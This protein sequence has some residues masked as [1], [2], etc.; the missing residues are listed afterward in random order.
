MPVTYAPYMIFGDVRSGVG[1][2]NALD[3]VSARLP[4]QFRIARVQSR[5]VQLSLVSEP[6]SPTLPRFRAVQSNSAS[7]QSRSVQLSLVSE[8]FSPTLPRFRA[9]QSNSASFQSRSVQLG[10]V[11][12][13]SVTVVGAIR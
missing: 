6:F 1:R 10:R 3:E 12:E 13:L 8:P 9:V 2:D 5:S 4:E 11:S 7:F